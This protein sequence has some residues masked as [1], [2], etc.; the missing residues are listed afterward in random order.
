VNQTLLVVVFKYFFLLGKKWGWKRKER[1]GGQENKRKWFGACSCFG[2][3]RVQWDE[4]NLN[5]LYL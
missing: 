5:G 3:W 4:S 2:L 1:W